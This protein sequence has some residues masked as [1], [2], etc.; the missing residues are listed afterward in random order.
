V[1]PVIVS[2]VLGYVVGSIPFA[3]ILARKVAKVDIRQ[4]GS[5]NVGGYN[6]YVVTQSKAMGLLVIVLDSLKGLLVVIVALWI[7]PDSYLSQCVALLGA[8]AGHNYPVW[9]GFKGGRGLAT[10]A[11]G[12]I[13]LG[14][15]FTAVWCII[16]F[17]AKKL[18]CDI[19]TANL[20]AIL[21]TPPILWM[22]PWEI[23]RSLIVVRVES[24]TFLFFAC[25]LSVVL[26]LSHNDVVREIWKGPKSDIPETPSP[27][28]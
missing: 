28:S 11:G 12:M 6:A 13:L 24:G 7:S 27:T 4:A 17:A 2:F 25:V 16:W 14:A 22:V 8:L 20:V 5:G 9:L 1:L 19:L 18:K 21:V 23:V 26:L 3:Y 15:S 10:A